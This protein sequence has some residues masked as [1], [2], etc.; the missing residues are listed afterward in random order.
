MNERSRSTDGEVTFAN[1]ENDS[2]EDETRSEIGKQFELKSRP[3]QIFTR[4]PS[5]VWP[6][7]ERSRRVLNTTKVSQCASNSSVVTDKSSCSS[8]ATDEEVTFANF[9]NDSDDDETRSEI[10]KQ[11]ELKSRPSQMFTRTPSRVWPMNERSRRVL[12]TTKVS[13]CASNSPVVTE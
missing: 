6:M 8:E 9:E 2:D 13:Q 12:N 11:F 1:F 10:G 7:N 5:R 4:T 3:S